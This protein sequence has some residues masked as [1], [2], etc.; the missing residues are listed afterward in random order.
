MQTIRQLLEQV[1]LSQYIEVFTQNDVDL[2]ALRL[3]TDALEC[4]DTEVGV[5][6]KPTR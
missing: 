6:E 4:R 1:G 2:E 3:L 5:L